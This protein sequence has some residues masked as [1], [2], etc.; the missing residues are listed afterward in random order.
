MDDQQVHDEQKPTEETPIPQSESENPGAIITPEAE[1]D[2]GLPAITEAIDPQEAETTEEEPAVPIEESAETAST[3]E[4]VASVV[5]AEKV[6]LSFWKRLRHPK[7]WWPLRVRSKLGKAATPLALLILVLVIGGAAFGVV[8]LK[9]KNVAQK[10]AAK[11]DLAAVLIKPFQVMS[12]TPS[13][14]EKD[15]QDGSKIVVT[16]NQ[17]VDATKLANSF[18]VTPKTTGTLAQGA[19]S[20]QVVYTPKTPF[21]N[22]TVVTIMIDDSFQSQLGQKLRGDYSLGFTT[23]IPANGVEFQTQNGTI[24]QVVSAQSS[25][26]QVLTLDVGSQVDPNGQ[27]VVYKGSLQPLLESLEYQQMQYPDGTGTYNVSPFNSIDTSGMQQLSSQTGLKDQSTINITQPEGIYLVAA[28]SGGKQVGWTWVVFNDNGTVMR[29]DDQQI[30]LSAF[31]LST[32]A[33]VSNATVSFYNLNGGVSLLDQETLN[34]PQAFSFPY[35]QEVDAA[36]VTDGQDVMVVPIATPNSLADSRVTEDLSTTR[37][38]YA[39]TDKPTYQLN[40][41]ANFA[42]YVNIDQDAQY[43]ADSEGS[44]S[45]YVASQDDPSTHLLNLSVPVGASG[46]FGGHFTIGSALTGQKD[47]AIYG[48]KD[49][50]DTTPINIATFA[51]AGTTSTDTLHVSFDKA[52]YLA[53]NSVNATVSG[54]TVT[55]QPLANATVTYNVYAEPYYDN[56]LKDN[57]DEFGTTGT[58]VGAQNQ[59]I[60]LN[61]QGQATIP[62]NNIA[63]FLSSGSQN[64]TVQATVTDSSGTTAD[65]GASAI[66][67]QGNMVLHFGTAKTFFD[68][69]DTRVGRLY[70]TDL[71]GKVLPNV[72]VSYQ[73]VDYTYD[74]AT[75]QENPT[76][77]ASG[78]ATTD[79][80]GYVQISQ[81]LNTSDEVTI[82]ATAQDSDGNQVQAED[83]TSTNTSSAPIMAGA[84]NLDYL[85]VSGSS[86]QATVGDS[87]PLTITAP[88][89]MN[90][91]ISYERG[92]VYKYQLLQ[93]N[94]GTNTYTV[95][96]TAQLAPSFNLVF[97]YFVD[98]QYHTEGTSFT[99]TNPQKQLSVTAT[100]D[101]SSYTAGQTANIKISTVD[102]T[103][104]A[105]S[106]NVIVAVESDSMFNLNSSFTPDMYSYYYAG[107][108]YS[109][110]SS[111]SLT[112]VGTGGGRCGGGGFYPTT[113]TNNVGTSLYWNPSLTTGAS[114][115]NT[116]SVA[117]PKGTWHVLVYA[118]GSNAAVGDTEMTVTAQ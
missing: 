52:S 63:S 1:Q 9:G 48:Y 31:N 29:Q 107:R 99:V 94:Q 117:L 20:E 84:D 71:N 15:V 27:I 81:Q 3:D 56:D 51:V 104:Q 75:Q 116:V 97:S 82:I 65:A 86:G 46:V 42:G 83:Y 43:A 91:L 26:K 22:S 37:T 17:P 62:V 19:N 96:V 111:S 23:E 102:G 109:T 74:S 6:K 103:N 93:L 40:D 55:G 88:K 106:S 11:D 13:T 12:T 38:F 16:F 32:N 5:V 59:T 118:I 61:S 14:G 21:A 7:L 76:V 67:H 112:G 53:G 114:G 98:G 87:I 4:V 78:S 18:I 69:N 25:T 2:D 44:L 72:P 58:Q 57:L 41:T 110:N 34:S 100:P 36:V 8:S 50:S 60:Q 33:T 113:L 89:S 28:I 115:T 79:S 95:D 66:V 105:V 24:N 39:V 90:V 10:V 85:D 64:V 70:V 35:S 92:R 101:Q 49:M 30:I 108:E 47:L 45:L 73:F 77:L 54:T 80:N 68:T